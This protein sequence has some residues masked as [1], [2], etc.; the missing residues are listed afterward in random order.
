MSNHYKYTSRPIRRADNLM[1]PFVLLC[2]LLLLPLLYFL[3]RPPSIPSIPNAT[4]NLPLI[5]NALSYGID[6]IK[7]LSS[8]KARHGDIF[9]VNLAIIRIV[10]FLGPEGSNT[11][12]RHTEKSGVSLYS[13][14]AFL[15]GES[16][17]K[18]HSPF[19]PSSQNTRLC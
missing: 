5:G 4:P 14:L 12:F 15:I 7:F 6:P 1:S 16:V 13:A 9:L 11:V 2:L 10:F 19:V 3:L 17:A 18:G 8:Q